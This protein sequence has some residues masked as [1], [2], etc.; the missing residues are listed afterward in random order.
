MTV[1]GEEATD[2][3]KQRKTE[4]NVVIKNIYY[5]M[6]YA[7]KALRLNDYRRLA[8]EDFDH[9]DDLLA[10]IL[11][12]AIGA[13][14]RRGFEREYL[15]IHE[16]LHTVRGHIDMTATARLQMAGYNGLAC[17]YD[18]FSEDTYKNRVLK[19]T[20]LLLIGRKDVDAVRKTDLKRCLIA[21]RDVGEVDIHRVDWARLRFHRNN[22]SYVL[23]M[24]VCQMVIERELFN[25]DEG[26]W[27][28]QYRSKRKLSKLY[29]KF[30]LEY[31]RVHH[32]ELSAS[33]K[34]VNRQAQGNIEFL[35]RLLTDVTLSR[36][37]RELII[38]A[39]CYGHILDVHYGKPIYAPK[40]IN[41]IQSY[42]LHEVFDNDKLVDGML[43]YAKVGNEDGHNETWSELEH[44]FSVR[45]MDLNRDFDAI[46]A[47]LDDIAVRWIEETGTKSEGTIQLASQ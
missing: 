7:F 12:I 16:N 36:G 46:A 20:A 27:S 31:Y 3:E 37:R 45:T 41:Q 28:M 1:G 2:G 47:D 33:A 11:A 21:M 5:M 42:V 30:V 13:Q 10:A 23:L 22:A 18:D 43:L 25:Q 35:P 4:D 39:K 14:R 34:T 26:N 9:I 44:H 6:T 15:P 24:N 32:P 17:V 8:T 38:D 40:H 29:E 19:T